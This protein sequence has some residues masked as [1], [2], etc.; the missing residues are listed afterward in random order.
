[1]KAL[2]FI[3]LLFIC[4][5]TCHVGHAQI[6]SSLNEQNLKS[7]KNI[8]QKS[9]PP[10]KQLNPNVEID[11]TTIYFS[12]I[13]SAQVYIKKEDWSKAESFIREAIVKEPSNHN[14]SLLISNL[15]TLQR[16]QGKLAEAV[17]NYTLA[18]DMTPNAV[19]LLQNRA[20]LFLKIDSLEKAKS[21]YNK[22]LQLEPSNEEARYN[23]GMM[24]L[25]QNNYKGAD[26]QFEEMLRYNPNSALSSQGKAYLNK[27]MGNYNK[28][29]E[30]FNDVIKVHPTASLL[31]NRADCLLMVKRLNDASTDIG[32]ALT[33]APND[34]Y[35]YLLRAKLNKMRWE[36]EAA[37][38]DVQL[39]I[40]HGVDENIAKNAIK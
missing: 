14:N 33:M 5:V 29:I 20:A 8:P 32:T 3:L 34:G 9:S 28:A 10:K 30:Y 19:A 26:A 21:D 35:L 23:L 16:Y 1:M 27:G 12:L 6:V 31:G 13:D 17:K 11:T 38:K 39:A 18:L 24:A 22:I 4:S 37:Q 40:E 15:A 2:Y 25:A 36:N 7:P